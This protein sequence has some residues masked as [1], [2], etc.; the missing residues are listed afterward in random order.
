[1]A[2]L[3]PDLVSSLLWQPDWVIGYDISLIS[4]CITLAFK[5]VPL[6]KSVVCMVCVC[7]FQCVEAM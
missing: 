1:M 7:V 4:A 3:A 5:E 6:I 2:R